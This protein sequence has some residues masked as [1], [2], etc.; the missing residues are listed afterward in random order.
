MPAGVFGPQILLNHALTDRDPHI[1]DREH[2]NREKFD[3]ELLLGVQKECVWIGLVW[4]GLH[5]PDQARPG[6]VKPDQANT[7]P[8]LTLPLSFHILLAFSWI[9]WGGQTRKAEILVDF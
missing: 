5:L 6:Q 4:S 8:P 3:D 9:Q 2:L 1:Q 7:D